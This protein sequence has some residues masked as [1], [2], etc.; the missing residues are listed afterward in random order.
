VPVR[1]LFDGQVPHEPGMGAMVSQQCLLGRRGNQA[2]PR[3]AN[4]LTNAPDI[5]EEVKRRFLVGL[6]PRSA[7]RESD[8]Y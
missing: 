7:R 4:I 2:V 5:S 6:S 3:H 1:V 8:E